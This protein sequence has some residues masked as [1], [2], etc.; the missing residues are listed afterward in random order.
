MENVNKIVTTE[1][2]SNNVA[3]IYDKVNL[4]VYIETEKYIYYI[5]ASQDYKLYRIFKYD[6]KKDIIVDCRVENVVIAENNIFYTIKHQGKITLI[7]CNLE[8]KDTYIVCKDL[9]YTNAYC[10]SHGIIYY[11]ENHNFRSYIK[12]MRLNHGNISIIHESVGC[13]STLYYFKDHIYYRRKNYPYKEEEVLKKIN[14]NEKL[15]EDVVE[16]FYNEVYFYKNYMIYQ[17][18]NSSLAVIK[19]LETGKKVYEMNQC[20]NILG[21][22]N[23]Y[24]LFTYEGFTDVEAKYVKNMLYMFNIET[25]NVSKLTDC[26][27]SKAQMIDDYIYYKTK[28]KDSR[29]YRQNINGE[30]KKIINISNKHY[31]MKMLSKLFFIAK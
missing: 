24:I 19:D 26:N 12:A 11:C 25:L 15:K 4:N 18:K 2:N 5:D 14:I 22:C 16:T 6:D 30:G 3:S 31:G 9:S 20:N 10:I 8:G 7:K 21:M 13:I 27:V 1:N 23:Q 17:Y 29:I 28:D